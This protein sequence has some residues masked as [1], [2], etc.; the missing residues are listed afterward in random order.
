M[1]ARRPVT[2][3]RDFTITAT[4]LFREY[5]IAQGSTRYDG[6]E[7]PAGDQRQRRFS[8]GKGLYVP[9]QL[10]IGEGGAGHSV[11]ASGFVAALN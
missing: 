6:V 3:A 2:R 11:I 10:D 4:A 1:V 7:Q 8:Y 5:Q 9:G